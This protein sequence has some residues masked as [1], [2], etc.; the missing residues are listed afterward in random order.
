MPLSYD[1][2][3]VFSLFSMKYM[4]SCPLNRKYMSYHRETQGPK[5]SASVSWPWPMTV[6]G[7]FGNPRIC[8]GPNFE[9]PEAVAIIL[10]LPLGKR[11]QSTVHVI[12]LVSILF[13]KCMYVLQ[14]L[15]WKHLTRQC[16][17]IDILI[18]LISALCVCADGYQCLSKVFTTLYK[19]KLFICSF[20]IPY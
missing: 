20:D 17:K 11:K 7:L 18:I 4:G 6:S 15:R 12:Q 8:W 9:R 19:Y 10:H 13:M 2:R 3:S 5:P 14:G 16:H 1:A